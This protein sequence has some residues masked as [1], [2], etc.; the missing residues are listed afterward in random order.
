MTE[1]WRPTT[2]PLVLHVIPTP[3]ARGAQREARALA[4]T[5]DLPGIRAHR[6][7]SLFNGPVEVR[8]DLSLG[9]PGGSA[10]AVGFDI[11]LVGKLRS[12]LRRLDPTLVV[13][14]GS[15]PLKYLVPAMAG[16]G[17]P[18]AY[19]AIGT[20]AG[21]HDRRLQLAVWRRLVA[22]VD[23]IAAEGNEVKEECTYLLG[24]PAERVTMTPNGRDPEV[25]RPRP[26]PARPLPVVTF[27]G[28]LTDGKRPDRFVE[29][30]AEL[31]RRAI[32]FR[33]QLVGDGP[34]RPS[35]VGPAAE[36]GVELLGSRS[37]IADILAQSD[38]LVFP[39]RPAGEGMPGVLIEAGLCGL[40]LVATD[41]P[42]VSTIVADGETGLVVGADDLS[43]MVEATARLL[44]DRTLRTQMGDAARQRCIELFS[45]DAVAAKWLE[46]LGPLLP[47]GA[48]PPG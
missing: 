1:L 27:V 3:L 6:V 26:G 4:D 37:D 28:A 7:L 35:L 11:R 13:A 5:L 30:V 21:S 2:E 14:H 36:A 16:Y 8:P 32:E 9:F 46:V 44:T 41:V 25:F 20:Y 22:R 45:L 23:A 42:G 12:A 33:A 24:V 40:P 17:R 15:D 10:P 19:Y 39:S 48:I 31:R 43:A 18:L 34:L 29:V 38:L 47:V